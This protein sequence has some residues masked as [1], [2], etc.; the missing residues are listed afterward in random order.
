MQQYK[1]PIKWRFDQ[2][3]DFEKAMTDCHQM[4][5]KEWENFFKLTRKKEKFGFRGWKLHGQNCS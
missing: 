3:M 4:Y 5:L 2:L 1:E